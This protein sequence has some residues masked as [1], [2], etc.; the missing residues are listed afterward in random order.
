[1]SET[2]MEYKTPSKPK[3]MGRSS[4]NPAKKLQNL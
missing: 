4:A 2:G 3:K 1:M